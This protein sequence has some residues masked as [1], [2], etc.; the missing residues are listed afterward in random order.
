MNSYS[1]TL[2]QLYDYLNKALKGS[3]LAND[4]V[5]VVAQVKLPDEA[6]TV[7]LKV[8]TAELIKQPIPESE[9]AKMAGMYPPKERALVILHCETVADEVANVDKGS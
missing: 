7:Y 5:R 3:Y 1:I 8:G 4:E 9:R 6:R 2:D